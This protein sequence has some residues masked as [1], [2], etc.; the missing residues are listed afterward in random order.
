ML[1]DNLGPFFATK[2][3]NR[4]KNHPQIPSELNHFERH[5]TNPSAVAA[6][7]V[8]VVVAAAVAAAAVVAAGVVAV[9]AAAAT[10]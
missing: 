5:S 10:L 2:S 3:S 6:V 8:V 4:L 9:A 1:S 7:V